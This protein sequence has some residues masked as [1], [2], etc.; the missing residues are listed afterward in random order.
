MSGILPKSRRGLAASAFWQWH[1]ALWL[2]LFSGATA[3]IPAAAQTSEGG[4][5]SSSGAGPEAGPAGTGGETVTAPALPGPIPDTL[6]P[7]PIGGFGLPSPTAPP[8]SV[9][10]QLPTLISPPTLRLQPSVGVVPIQAYDPNA[11]AVLIRPNA[12]LGETFYDNVNY[13]HSPRKFAALTQLGG[14]V[15]ASVDTPR[16]QAVATGEANG[17]I[18]LPGSNSSLNQIFGS[19]YANGHGTVYPD[20]FYVDAQSLITQGSTLPG[21]GFQNLST[22]PRNQQ[23]QQFINV[24][25]PYLIKSFGPVADTELR[26]T[27]SSSNYGGNT[28]VTASPLVPGL[29]SLA[30]TT[31]N[32]G[33]FIAATGEDFQK[34]LAR[35]TADAAEL[36]GS[37]LNQSTQVSA[38]NDFQYSFTPAIAALGR[39]GY[40]N[41]RYPGS[42][43]ATF[44][45]ATWLAGGRIGTVGPDQPAYVALQYGRQQGSY[46]FTGSSQVNITPSMVFSA[47]LVQGISSQGQ[48]F[49]SNLANS[50]LTP[51]GAIVNQST[52]LPTTF[53]SPGLGLS[54]SVFR[55]H[56]FNAGVSDVLP[57]NY[58]SLF[59]FYTEQQQLSTAVAVPT[60]SLGVNF[61]YTRDIRP[62]VSGSASIGFVNSVNSPTVVPGTTTVNFNQTTS[63]DSVNATLGL[64]YV[65]ARNLTLSIVYNFSYTTNGTVLV[66][67]RNGDV[68]ANQLQFL[69]SKTF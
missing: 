64:N 69:L 27:F 39:A 21:F 16:L 1:F 37:P 43:A 6:P 2:L 49:A 13:V 47:N 66:G 22:L 56:L 38:Y 33:T 54:S 55:Q 50:T 62:D 46:G 7:P 14:G 4:A 57:P 63:F 36:N 11:P 25:S 61:I 24:V 65:L 59:A 51:S 32:E 58:Y 3:A 19:L 15:S 44:G 48:L 30:S 40:Q 60:K 8:Y 28:T 41:L 68:F 34:V 20:L 35:F 9:N 45:G 53:S 67:G 10:N 17:N 18:Y 52:G 12:S 29:G 31:L 23:T 5:P 26:Y 42:P